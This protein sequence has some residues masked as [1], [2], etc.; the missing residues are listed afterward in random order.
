MKSLYCKEYFTG[1]EFNVETFLST[2]PVQTNSWIEQIWKKF[3][4]GW[5]MVLFFSIYY[6]QKPCANFLEAIAVSDQ[7]QERTRC[8]PCFGHFCYSLA[9]WGAIYVYCVAHIK[10][11]DDVGSLRAQNNHIPDLSLFLH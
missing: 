11:P 5:E 9:F 10:V 2:V 1:E 7:L 3:A 6:L 4:T 8:W